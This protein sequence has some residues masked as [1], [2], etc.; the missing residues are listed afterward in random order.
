M[1]IRSTKILT[2][3]FAIGFGVSAGAAEKEP[4]LCLSKGSGPGE[5]DSWNVLKEKEMP[6]ACE[7]VPMEEGDCGRWY[8]ASAMRIV[9]LRDVHFEF[10]K[11]EL[12]EM[13]KPE[14]KRYV[15]MMKENPKA[16]IRI[17]GHTDSIGAEEVNEHLSLARAKSIR[18]FLV[19][20]GVAFHRIAVWGEGESRP[21]TSNKTEE[22]R[23]ENRRV[24]MKLS[25][26][27]SQLVGQN[28]KII[29]D[30]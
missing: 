13:A 28:L 7:S 14:L 10:G 18:E 21:I 1:K 8:T 29:Y 22:G 12:R 9:V 15:A 25:G 3:A 4:G 16:K 6:Q 11:S 23:R 5:C 2:I 30:R 20:E 24:D 26:A 17:V 27:P 19:K